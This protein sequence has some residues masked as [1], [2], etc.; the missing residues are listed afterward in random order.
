MLA[1]EY[2]SS[3]AIHRGNFLAR[4]RIVAGLCD[5]TVVVESDIRGGAMS[6][7]RIAAEY[8][9]DVMALPG[10]VSD[11]YTAVAQTN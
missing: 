4:N 6:T 9:R 2:L 10:R 1:T 7:A 3:S 8:G 11:P 5:V